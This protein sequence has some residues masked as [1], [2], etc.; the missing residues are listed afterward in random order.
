MCSSLTTLAI[1]A[2]PVLNGIRGKGGG[3][4]ELGALV[5]AYNVAARSDAER[6]TARERTA[7]TRVLS[8]NEELQA[9]KQDGE[10]ERTRNL[11][12][13]LGAAR[14]EMEA[15]AASAAQAVVDY[16]EAE[17]RLRRAEREKTR[18]Q[19]PLATEAAR[20]FAVERLRQIEEI[21]A[22]W[23]KL[24]PRR[25]VSLATGMRLVFD[26]LRQA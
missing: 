14:S 1:E 19:Q 22:T 13:S 24:R 26:G 5:V 3:A 21:V 25:D 15:S 23:G 4:L 10:S 20:G 11:A 9:A 17:R 8:L 7:R 16:T 2:A 6:A 12:S 18:A